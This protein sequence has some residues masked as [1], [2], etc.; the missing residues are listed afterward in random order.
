ME[1]KIK[2]T[3]WLN[4]TRKNSSKLV[5]VYLRVK[6]N[7]DFFTKSTGLL[8]KEVDWDKKAMRV[9]GNTHDANIA[10]NSGDKWSMLRFY[11]AGG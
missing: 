5:P 11:P 8:I 9:K 10:H 1:S 2:I 6:Y 7:Y 4:K 3:F